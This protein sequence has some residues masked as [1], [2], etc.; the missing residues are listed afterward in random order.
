MRLLQEKVVVDRLKATKVPGVDARIAEL[1]KGLP[2]PEKRIDDLIKKRSEGFKTFKSD[3]AKGKEIF[4]KNCAACHQVNNEGAKVGPQLDGIG[5]RG[6]ERLLEDTLDPSRNVDAAFKATTLQLLDGRS[7]SGLVR[8][9]GAV[10]V[11]IDNLGKESRIAVKDVEQVVKS[12][13]S[14]MPANVDAIIP[15]ADYY[16]LLAFLLSQKPK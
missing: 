5:I 12:N 14:A 3:S 7:L 15:E 16:H 4:A 8:E 2:A 6:V 11:L 9:D 1:T 13:L 10:Y